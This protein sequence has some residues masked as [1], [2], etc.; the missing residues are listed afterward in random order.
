MTTT[1]DRIRTQNDAFRTHAAFLGKPI[2]TG[3]LVITRSIANEGAEFAR[4]AV[5]LVRTYSDFTPDNDPHGEHDFGSFEL[6]GERLFWKIDY[7]DRALKYGSPAPEDPK[8]TRRV[9]TILLA[10]EY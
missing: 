9:L 10:Q 6:D 4:R 5:E 7:Y 1:T 8:Q 2:L 3:D